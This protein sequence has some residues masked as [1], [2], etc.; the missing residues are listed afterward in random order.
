MRIQPGDYYRPALGANGETGVIV[1]EGLHDLELDLSQVILRGA[2][3]RSAPDEGDGFGLV[4]RN[5]EGLRIRGGQ[6]SGYRVAVLVDSSDDIRLEGLVI[7]PVFGGRLAGS[8]TLPN[9]D[10]RLQVEL[11]DSTNWIETYGAAIAVVD[12]SRIEVRECKACGG[13]NGLILLRSESCRVISNDF[14][15]LSGWGIALAQSDKNLVAGN[16]CD[17]VTR[18]G[19]G[20][21]AEPD[22]GS[23]GLLLTSGSSDNS[24]C[25]NSA[26]RCSAGGREIFGGRGSGKGNRWYANDFSGAQCVSFELD[27]SEDTWFVANRI[28]GS[29]GT[30][31]RAHST[32]GLTLVRNRIELVH[33]SGIS[34]QDARHAIVFENQLIDCDL[35][36]EILSARAAQDGDG[37]AHWIAANH[38]EE[39]IQDLVLEHSEGLE[40]SGNDF[41]RQSNRAHLDGLT[42][43]G[44]EELAAREVWGLLRDSEGHLPSGRSSASRLH[45]DTGEVPPVLGK[46]TRW[47]P[48]EPFDQ[49]PEIPDESGAKFQLGTLLGD[50]GPW[51]PNGGTPRPRA[52][53]PRGLV[54]GVEWDATWFQWNTNSD[55]R[56]DIERWRAR[57]FDPV[58][59][60][61]VHLWCDP[62]GGSDEVRESVPAKSFGMIANGEIVVDHDGTYLLSEI[63]DD[64]LRVTIDDVV[65]LEDWTWHPERQRSQKIDLTAGSHLVNLEYFQIDGAAVLSLELREAPG[66]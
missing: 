16:R 65:V 58:Q 30:G 29:Q 1:L 56:G 7:D 10:D 15:Y 21:R 55:P 43:V 22:H 46:L 3:R 52:K 40:F 2:P 27:R 39:N 45:Q 51:D 12:S 5:C 19:S 8:T 26:R 44:R 33:G 32:E 49:L 34:L 9:P 28:R 17:S 14:S 35:A 38:F 47:S 53:G 62:W 23:T 54:A 20:G 66:P 48:P 42:A 64:G 41:E 50:F 60:A 13:Q 36:L 24:L 31:V 11:D 4:I 63:S 18:Q 37:R 25:S 61:R 59:R 57:R 6:F